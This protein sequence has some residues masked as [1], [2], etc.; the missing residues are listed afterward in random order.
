M[1]SLSSGGVDGNPTTVAV[2]TDEKTDHYIELNATRLANVPFYYHTDFKYSL[3]KRVAEEFGPANDPGWVTN[4]SRNIFMDW[5]SSWLPRPD[6]IP[7]SEYLANITEFTLYGNITNIVDIL[8][9]TGLQTLNINVGEALFSTGLTVSEDIN[10]APLSKL[11]SLTKVVIGAGVPL[12]EADF[13]AAGITGV[14]IV[15]N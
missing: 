15:K 4:A 9:F 11:S 3:S 1:V 12:T 7:S 13:T 14:T 10:L 5:W 2:T 8:P 6:L